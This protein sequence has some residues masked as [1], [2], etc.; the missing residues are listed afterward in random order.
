[1]QALGAQDWIPCVLEAEMTL[2]WGRGGTPPQ[3]PGQELVANVPK[4]PEACLHMPLSCVSLT[5]IPPTQAV[6]S[7]DSVFFC[8]WF[9]DRYTLQV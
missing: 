4:H 2:T 5:D 9:T 1:M 6:V 3:V 8:F 7:C